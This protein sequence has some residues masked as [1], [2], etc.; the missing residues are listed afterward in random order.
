MELN[1]FASLLA[2]GST[3]TAK[4]T[5]SY[6]IGNGLNN[7]SWA[8]ALAQLYKSF[9]EDIKTSLDSRKEFLPIILK[10][11]QHYSLTN[12]N[13]DIFNEYEDLFSAKNKEDIKKFNP[14]WKWD[15]EPEIVFKNVLTFTYAIPRKYNESKFDFIEKYESQFALFAIKQ[16]DKILQHFTSQNIWDLLIK[17]DYNKFINFCEKYDFDRLQILKDLIKNSHNIY[18][19]EVFAQESFNYY[20]ED[21]ITIGKTYLKVIEDFYPDSEWQGLERNSHTVFHVLISAIGNH[22][23]KSAMKWLLVFEKELNKYAKLYEVTNIN[24]TDN[25]KQLLTTQI[26]ILKKEQRSSAIETHVLEKIFN[27][28]NWFKYMDS[29]AL[30][31]H[32]NEKF[33]PREKTKTRK[34]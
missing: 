20:L 7:Q 18:K 30:F 6:L 23:Y 11:F 29:F 8:K 21:L 22:Q 26:N 17:D 14:G 1:E 27:D 28:E 15:N 31:N 10:Y 34:I 32:L 5:L 9:P 19:N 33:L 24:T 3:N 2:S 16:K 25:F 12:D 13:I 4:N